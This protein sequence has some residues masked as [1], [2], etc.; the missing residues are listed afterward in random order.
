VAGHVGVPHPGVG[1]LGAGEHPRLGRGPHRD[2]A[3]GRDAPASGYSYRFPFERCS[4]T[5]DHVFGETEDL[6]LW[7]M[8][9]GNLYRPDGTLSCPQK[10]L[11]GRDNGIVVAGLEGGG[12]AR[13]SNYG[14]EYADLAAPWQAEGRP[15]VMGTS[16]A[17]PRVAAVAAML[18]SKYDR[19]KPGDLRMALLAG[20]LPLGSLQTT[21]RS[22]GALDPVAANTFAACVQQA[23]EFSS[24][25]QQALAPEDYVQCARKAGATDERITFLQSR[26][27]LPVP[28]TP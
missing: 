24:C 2:G 9:A 21:V 18:A 11:A 7:V 17:S 27:I 14:A 3:G 20:S 1:G 19:L 26:G 6:L 16:Y 4:D 13:G 28:G 10:R 23:L 12:V 22:G 5:E 25:G 15:E 8:S